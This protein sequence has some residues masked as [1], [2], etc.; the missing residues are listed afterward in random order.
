[1]G[2]PNA[3]CY[4]IHCHRPA[5]WRNLAPSESSLKHFENLSYLECFHLFLS[6]AHISCRI[7]CACYLGESGLFMHLHKQGFRCLKWSTWVWVLRPLML[8][9]R[10]PPYIN[11]EITHLATWAPCK[12]LHTH[13]GERRQFRTIPPCHCRSAVEGSWWQ[14]GM[15][16]SATHIQG[17][18]FCLSGKASSSVAARNACLTLQDE[19]FN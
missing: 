1:M 5:S 10:P 17:W 11:S 14:D 9:Q 6:H 19:E 2:S 3:Q 13:K 15:R 18:T 8:L 12:P 4:H 7:M 16:L